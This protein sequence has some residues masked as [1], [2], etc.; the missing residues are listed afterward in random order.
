MLGAELR[1]VR[2]G[3]GDGQLAL[4]VEGDDR[5]VEADVDLDEPAGIAPAAASRRQLEDP[6]VEPDR[7]IPGN[8]AAVLEDEHP[9][10][11]DVGRHRPPG[12]HR[13][14]RRDIEAG[15]EAR[16]EGAEEDIRAVAV[17]D[18]GQPQLDDQ[19]VLERAP[20][21]LDPA[22]GLS[23]AGGD[24]ADPELDEG[25][26]DLAELLGSTGLGRSRRGRG[27]GAVAIVV[28]APGRPWVPI[29]ARRI[30]R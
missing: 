11:P 12:R 9:L 5:A 22:L 20:Q 26:P 2:R 27:E 17:D 7:V 6:A 15:I 30:S 18:V 25:P 13:I 10:E 16:Q 28:S 3:R 23:R 21:P 24:R 14:G 4:A 1:R 8:L 29:V 19:P